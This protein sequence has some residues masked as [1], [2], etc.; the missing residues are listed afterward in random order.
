MALPTQKDDFPA[1][2][3]EVVKQAGLAEPS[4]GTRGAFVIKP[5]GYAI[6]E[7]IRDAVDA[8]IKSTGHENLYFPML[9]PNHLLELEKDHAEG[10]AS[11]V[12][13]VTHAGGQK[14]EGPLVVRPTSETIIWATYAKW[15]QSYRDLPLL[16]NQWANVVRW[17]L[18]PRV[19]LR[20][21]EFL[22]Q[23]GHTA[24]ETS[25]EAMAETLRI[26]H[27]VYADA[28]E[29]VLG[30]PVLRGR[31][32]ASERFP[33]AEE[34]F[35][36]EAMMRD[37]KALQ[38][39]TS[40]Y[41]GQKLATVYGVQFQSRAG[42]L[43]HAY[44]T[45]WGV[46]TR[47]VGGVI[48]THGDDKGL[49]L[50][51]G[52]APHQVVIVPIFKSDEDRARVYQRADEVRRALQ[53]WRVKVDER[54]H[55]RPGFKY[56]EWELKGVPVRIDLGPRDVEA[57]HLV[58]ARRDGKEKETVPTSSAPARV[59]EVLAEIQRALFDDAARFR[60]EHTFQP[61]DYGEFKALLDE[62][63]GFMEG[64]WCGEATCEAEIKAETKATIRILPLER[65]PVSGPCLHC[66]SDAAERATW[67]LSY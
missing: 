44:A 39:G 45:S 16:Y 25:E 13:V 22:W 29:S 55:L 52:I 1:W 12:A 5:Y 27:E 18:R 20:T 60:S 54:D 59:A 65:E 56:N 49:R 3:Q 31:K 37:G 9:I 61:K 33:G 21:T 41:F 4:L 50:P 66:G 64:L 19:F 51:P 57:D 24:H 42:E 28:V 6:W 62:P 47:L 8:R 34:T 36:I 32:S 14:L 35:T 63:G 48:M 46:S 58:I 23:E 26:L 15:V 40:H 11:E 10:F 38:S 43:E 30:V 67:G 17:E 53:G 2:Y 7:A